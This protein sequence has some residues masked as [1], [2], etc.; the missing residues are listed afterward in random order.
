LRDTAKGIAHGNSKFTEKQIKEIRKTYK[1]GSHDFGIV[2]IAKK[3][4]VWPTTIYKIVNNKAWT[5]I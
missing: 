1:R 5:H 2:A 4:N 3:Y